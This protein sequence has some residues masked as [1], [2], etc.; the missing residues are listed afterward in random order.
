[1][2][3]L[4]LSEQLAGYEATFSERAFLRWGMWLVIVGFGGFLSWASFAPLD[5]GV[6][7][8][9]SVVVTGNR[10]AVQHPGGGVIA[11]LRVHDGEK[12]QAGQVLAVMNTVSTQTRRDALQSQLRSLQLQMARLRA[13]RTG[14]SDL[15]LLPELLAARDEP[16]VIEQLALQRQLLINRRAALRSELAAI[17]EGVAGTEALLAGMQSLLRSKQQ[18]KQLLNEQLSGIRGLAAKGYVARNQLLSMEGQLASVEGE[19]AETHGSIGRLQRQIIELRLQAQQ[20][21]DEYSKEVNTQLAD[22]QAQIAALKNQLEK[23]EADLQDTQIRAPVTG[24]VVGMAVFTE[25]GVI[26]AGQQLMEIVP[27]DSPMEVEARVPV[28][29][30]DKVHPALPV[31]LLFSAFDQSTTPRVAGEVTMVGADRLVDAQTGKPYYALRVKVTREGMDKLQGLT[32]RPGM[33][34]EG[35][36]RTGERSLMNYLLKPLTDRLHL[37]LTES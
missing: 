37:A 34:V 32:I 35:F 12:V 16:E 8:S 3:A 31:E 27:E 2:K 4:A 9:G 25:G 29:L 23:A 20:R 36:I 21:R 13:E 19:I 5:R 11:Q 15:E 18:Q 10:K 24:T 33:P 14:E 6:P 1:M 22:G 26:Q 28:E 30:I 17:D 7:V